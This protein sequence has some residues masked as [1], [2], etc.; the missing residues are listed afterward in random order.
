MQTTYFTK[1]AIQC[2]MSL[3]T[4]KYKWKPN[5]PAAC[6]PENWEGK[7]GHVQCWWRYEAT[8][9]RNS[10][11]IGTENIDWYKSL[12]KILLIFIQF[13]QYVRI[14]YDLTI[15][16]PNIY[17]TEI[18]TRVHPK[19]STSC[20]ISNS[21]VQEATHTYILMAYSDCVIQRQWTN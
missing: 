3:V 5:I 14:F 11:N 2:P 9:N 6:A 17:P 15:L 10:Q 19:T 16:L 18:C 21:Q 20:I 7:A 8:G 4:R 13:C 1:G 12:W